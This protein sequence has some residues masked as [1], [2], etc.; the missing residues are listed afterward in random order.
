MIYTL[1]EVRECVIWDKPAAIIGTGSNINKFIYNEDKVNVFMINKAGLEYEGTGWVVTV[2]EHLSLIRR[3]Y[4]EKQRIINIR[5]KDIR[6][7]N[8][9]YGGTLGHILDFVAKHIWSGN[10]IFLQGIDLYSKEGEK[11]RNWKAYK[12]AVW[13]INRRFENFKKGVK[14]IRINNTW[15]LKFLVLGRPSN[16][17]LLKEVK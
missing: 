17:L 7:Y 12:Q 11:D 14:I 9:E 4:P 3:L 10:K 8:L 2:E 15:Q 1:D 16:K 5:N 13:R 6:K